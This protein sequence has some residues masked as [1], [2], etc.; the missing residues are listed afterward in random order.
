[1]ADDPIAKAAAEQAR[2]NYDALLRPR[3][4]FTVA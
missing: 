1:M 2:D 4:G 3:P